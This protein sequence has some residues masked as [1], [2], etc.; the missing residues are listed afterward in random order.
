M[1][2]HDNNH[3]MLQMLD[4]SKKTPF[5][6]SHEQKSETVKRVTFEEEFKHTM[7]M[8]LLIAVKCEWCT[9]FK[10]SH[11]L[12]NDDPS[13]GGSNTLQLLQ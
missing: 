10:E 8:G 5:C 7:A 2:L 1:F 11:T 6:N 12:I 9:H 13:R 3:F 4:A